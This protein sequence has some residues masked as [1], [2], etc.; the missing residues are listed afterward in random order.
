TVYPNNKLGFIWFPAF[1]T[2][3]FPLITLLAYVMA[4]LHV[5]HSRLGVAIGLLGTMRASGGA[6]GG[7]IHNTVFN[8]RFAHYVGPEVA[9]AAIQNDLNPADLPKI[10]PRA[11]QFDLG[12]P[13]ALKGI[14]GVTPVVELALREAVRNA[15]GHAFKMV[16]YV[17]IPFTVIALLCGLLAKDASPFMT[18][19]T[20]F[21]M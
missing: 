10:V 4:S 3:L 13:G 8:N 5:P 18:N 1:G 17:T 15:Y 14:E 21:A 12:V 9:K 6:V 7:A 20:Q 19:H 2:S 16:F 11:I